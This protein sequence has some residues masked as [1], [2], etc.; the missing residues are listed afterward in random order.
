VAPLRA[1]TPEGARDGK[2]VATLISADR[3]VLTLAKV[4]V[5]GTDPIIAIEQED[6]FW[7]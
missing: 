3:S 2:S 7:P 5:A 6:T 1:A 4:M